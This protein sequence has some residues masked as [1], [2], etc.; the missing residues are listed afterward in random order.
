MNST[1]WE[2][3]KVPPEYFSILSASLLKYLDL[4]LCYASIHSLMYYKSETSELFFR[5]E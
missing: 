5:L 1:E 2:K 3:I 4:D